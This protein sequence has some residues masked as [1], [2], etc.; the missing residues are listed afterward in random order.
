MAKLMKKQRRVPRAL[1]TDKLKSYPARGSIRWRARSSR[2]PDR[3]HRR[4]P[5]PPL[6]PRRERRRHPR[7]LGRAEEAQV[8]EV[9][10]RGSSSTWRRPRSTRCCWTRGI[11]L[12][13]ESTMYRI[14]RRHGEV[15][16]RRRQATRH[17]RN[18]S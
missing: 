10:R 11:Y 15:R 12:C 2:T 1:V 16:E 17:A 9:L 5:A 13:S 6:P 8:L 14:L 3:H 4:S 18:R 7:A